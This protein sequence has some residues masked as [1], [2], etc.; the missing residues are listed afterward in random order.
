MK[1]IAVLSAALILAAPALAQSFM[2]VALNQPIAASA[3]AECS[4][5]VLDAES[6]A[7]IHLTDYPSLDKLCFFKFSD[8][9]YSIHGNHL[10]PIRATVS[11]GRV[12]ILS[13]GFAS[14][15]D[16]VLRTA[17]EAKMGRPDGVEERTMQNGMGA[18]FTDH[19]E[20]WRTS[21]LVVTYDTVADGGS[22]GG[23]IS[24]VSRQYLA[25]AAQADGTARAKATA[26]F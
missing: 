24:A 20:D 23:R 14:L 9:L 16:G 22:G 12:V 19:H 8:T 7:A 15:R 10:G 4:P 2:G 3:P 13:L 25:D 1:I 18:T 11:D 26:A 5:A 6:D 17:L 21:D